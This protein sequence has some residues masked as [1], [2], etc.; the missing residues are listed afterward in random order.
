MIL[1]AGFLRPH[2]HPFRARLA[3]VVDVSSS[4]KTR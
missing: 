2:W 4:L 3:R 1:P